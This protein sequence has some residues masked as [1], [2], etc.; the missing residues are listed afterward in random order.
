MNKAIL[1]ST[2]AVVAASACGVSFAQ[3]VPAPIPLDGQ[4]RGVGGASLSLTAGNASS[5]ALLLNASAQR[6]TPRD[7]IAV[8]GFVNYASS[9]AASTSGRAT[10]AKKW[11]GFG[12]YDYNINPRLF[13]FGRLG[14]EGDGLIELDV[15]AQL[16]GGVGYKVINTP[17]TQFTVYGGLAHTRDRYGAL[18]FIDGKNDDSFSRT[19]LYLAE[20]SNHR[21]SETVTFNQRL[22]LLPGLTGDK[23]FIAKFQ[24]G[25][26]VA[27]SSTLSLNVGLLNTYNSKSPLGAKKNDV[28]L[29][30]GVNTKF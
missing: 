9:D 25:L 28:A 17:N 8:G 10:T 15:R 21:L 18:Q 7:T 1:R 2:L 16:A 30:T 19:S 29:Y 20:Q 13:A 3:A 27:M 23:A 12:Q 5:R 14:L 26:G 4:W 6:L 24:A 22:E 11:A